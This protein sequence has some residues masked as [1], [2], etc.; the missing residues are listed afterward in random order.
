MVGFVRQLE[1]DAE[2]REHEARIRAEERERCVR[3]A[4]AEAHYRGGINQ[5]QELVAQA[6]TLILSAPLHMP[7]WP[8]N[9][10]R[11]SWVRD[12]KK[13]LDAVQEK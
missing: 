2:L 9:E 1:I 5:L 13:W 8:E 6:R 7:T 4:D 11:N 12:S 10:A 3:I